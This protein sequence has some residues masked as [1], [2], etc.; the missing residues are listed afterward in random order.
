MSRIDDKINEI[1]DYLEKL[2][3][4]VPSNVEDYK[5]DHKTI[6][7]C[8]RYFERIIESIIDSCFLVVKEKGF[9]MPE[10]EEKVFDVLSLNK[11]IPQ[12]LAEKLKDAKGMRNIIAHDYGKVEDEIEKLEIEK[13]IL[14]NK[15]QMTNWNTKLLD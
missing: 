1:E 5:K 8:E 11:I 9:K 10:E 13:G 4:I 3:E 7:A 6:A 15:L 2:L 14:D 12:Q